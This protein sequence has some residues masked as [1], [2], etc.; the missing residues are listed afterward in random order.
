MIW[1]TLQILKYFIHITS[2]N[3]HNNTV[4]AQLTQHAGARKDK[5]HVGM[6]APQTIKM[7]VLI[8]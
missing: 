7:Q 2:F 4:S 6:E 3:F 1:S 5:E 8:Q